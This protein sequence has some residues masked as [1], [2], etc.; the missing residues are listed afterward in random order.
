MRCKLSELYVKYKPG[1]LK[2]YSQSVGVSV[3]NSND[4]HQGQT[5]HVSMSSVIMSPDNNREVDYL[6]FL[7]FLLFP[8]GRIHANHLEIVAPI[9]PTAR[10]TGEC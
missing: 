8:R 10:N 3:L 1:F 5:A 2:K 6:S 4:D 7:L 9:L